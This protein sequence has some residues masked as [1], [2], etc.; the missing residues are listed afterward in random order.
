MKKRQLFVCFL[1]AILL[2]LLCGCNCDPAA[3]MW[4][5]ESFGKNTVYLNGVEQMER[6][7]TGGLYFTKPFSGMEEGIV[8]IVFTESGAVTFQPGT[9][10]TLTGTFT[11]KNNGMQNTSF[12]VTLD[13]G[14]TFSG[15]AESYYYG[16][17][18]EFNFRGNDY[19]FEEAFE[20][21]ETLYKEKIQDFVIYLRRHVIEK[22]LTPGVVTVSDGGYTL[23]MEGEEAP[24]ALDQ[25]IAVQCVRLD[26]EN[27]MTLLDAIEPGE[28]Y[29]VTGQTYGG[30][31]KI[32][33]YYVEPLPAQP[34][35]PSEPDPTYLSDLRP[36]LRDFVADESDYI[37]MTH[38]FDSLPPG[39]KK[40]HKY[41][42]DQAEVQAII[43]RLRQ[44][45]VVAVTKE[46]FAAATSD[47]VITI[48]IYSGSY[49]LEIASHHGYFIRAEYDYYRLEDFPEFDY[50]NAVRSFIVSENSV[51]KLYDG[52]EHMGIYPD[53]D[54]YEF[55]VD[56]EEHDYTSAHY[57][58]LVCEF[59]EIQIYDERHFRYKGQNYVIVGEW[60]FEFA[61]QPQ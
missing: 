20:T 29:C 49:E 25:T 60:C 61:K 1:F 26:G 14:E 32:V 47:E 8:S 38:E 40:H 9:G 43:D 24:R 4:Y 52:D 59:G 58:T 2:L 18:L 53:L 11:T 12:T 19:R 10:E 54:Q 23:T 57:W 39:Y 37:K 55:V 28:C 46:E 31:D 41:I 56:T 36:W 21:A 5:V 6:Y 35:V 3:H 22:A 15:I 51:A 27:N 42:T 44:I 17:S 16:R 50:T 45:E 7:T 48:R 13:N 30:M 33:I 34:T